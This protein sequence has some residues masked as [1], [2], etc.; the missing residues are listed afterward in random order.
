MKNKEHLKILHDTVKRIE[1]DKLAKEIKAKEKIKE[2]NEVYDL[3][4][5]A[6]L[7]GAN[8]N[9]EYIGTR[10]DNFTPASYEINISF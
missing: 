9:F 10:R 8:P 5:H 1:I 3:L 7:D 4:L 6:I 2:L